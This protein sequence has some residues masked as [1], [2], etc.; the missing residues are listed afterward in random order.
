MLNFQ[1][2]S[3]RKKLTRIIM[4]TCCVS[5]FLAISL[6]V[7]HEIFSY[8]KNLVAKVDTLAKV[9]ANNLIAPLLFND[10]QSAEETLKALKGEPHILSACV[11]GQDG[12]RFAQYLKGKGKANTLAKESSSIDCPAT[13]A[14]QKE[15][16]GWVFKNNRLEVSR[17]ILSERDRLGALYIISDLGDLYSQLLWYLSMAILIM[18]AISLIAYLLSKKLQKVI[19]DP[20]LNLAQSMKGVSEKK[21]YSLRM[22]YQG[23][24]ELGILMAGFNEMLSEISLRDEQLQNSRDQLEKRVVERTVELVKA[25]RDLARAERLAREHENWLDNILKSVLTGIF[26]VDAHSHRILYANGLACQ[27]T[28]KTEDELVGSVCH[29]TVCPAAVNRCPVTDLG[30]T[31]DNSERI[32]LHKSGERIPI[33]KNV[34]RMNFQGR[35]ILLESFINIAERKQMEQQLLT[36]K[37]AA[38]TSNIAKSQFLA[39][40]SHE[41]RTPMNGVIGFLELLQREERMTE[42]Q[43]RYIA[44]ALNSGEILLQLI[45]DILDLSKIEAGKM[46]I[47]ATELN[48]LNLT[49]DVVNS[50]SKQAQMK[51]I[52]LS[53]HVANSIPSVLR[54]D[55]VRLRQI[56]FNL[57]GNAVKFTEKG[58]VSLDVSTEEEMEQSLLIR[59]EVRD[60]GIGI[61]PEALTKIFDAFTQADGSTTR[62]YGGTGLGLT[63][64]SQLA[65]MMGGKIDVESVHGKGSTFRFTARLERQDSTREVLNALASLG[66]SIV[67]RDEEVHEHSDGPKNKGEFSSFQV[68]LVEDNPVNQALGLAMLEYFGCRTDVAENGQEALEAFSIKSYDIIMMDCQMPLMDGYEATRAIRQEERNRDGGRESRH[69]PIVALTAHAME[70]D[71]ETCLEAGMDDY[72]SKPYKSDELYAV[73]SKWLVSGSEGEEGGKN[74]RE[75]RKQNSR[76]AE[77]DTVSLSSNR[78]PPDRQPPLYWRKN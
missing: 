39:N 45:N 16:T 47:V 19:S 62:Q 3:I 4:M 51:G 31:I 43:H 46:E 9:T 33:I 50:F 37:E 68:L 77:Q 63:I 71:R 61:A 15:M 7:T 23:T 29:E 67:S 5:L 36:A 18:G 8:R 38:E 60:T 69:I 53:C 32:L 66:E 28:G 44:M 22:N 56:L 14:P 12:R 41:I 58:E 40:M 49:E 13:S 17:V 64:A 70:G 75:V 59:F 30:Q 10:Q 26:I 20:I 27:L 21:D 42:Q 35:D 6:F 11:F 78:K 76:D 72:L 34:I 65:P 57:L 74:V 24:D 73:L 55:P 52:E 48:L 2:S 1:N 54:G 25:N